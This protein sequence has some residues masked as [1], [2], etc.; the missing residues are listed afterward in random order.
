MSGAICTFSQRVAGSL[1]LVG[2]LFCCPNARGQGEPPFKI[3]LAGMAEFDPGLPG[4]FHLR[5]PRWT[6]G[7]AAGCHLALQAYK[8]RG[9]KGIV[10]ANDVP[11]QMGGGKVHASLKLPPMPFNSAAVARAVLYV[12]TWFA[13]SRVEALLYAANSNR[14]QTGYSSAGQSIWLDRVRLA[15]ASEEDLCF[16]SCAPGSPLIVCEMGRWGQTGGDLAGFTL[17][18]PTPRK[19]TKTPDLAES[20]PARCPFRDADVV[21]YL[22]ARPG[23][24]TGVLNA[25]VV[26][27]T[28]NHQ[29]SAARCFVDGG[30]ES[31]KTLGL[32]RGFAWAPR[33]FHIAG[34]GTYGLLAYYRAQPKP[35]DP[36]DVRHD[37]WV[38]PVSQAGRILVGH[39][40]KV[41]EGVAVENAELDPTPPAWHP[42]GEH[43]FFLQ[44]QPGSNPLY[45]AHVPAGAHFAEGK[46][47]ISS[48]QLGGSLPMDEQLVNLAVSCSGDGRYLA[49]IASGMLDQ[50][51]EAK[52]YARAFILPIEARQ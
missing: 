47:A 44:F 51:E 35:D 45:V 32:V 21:A 42:D 52:Y 18:D 27:R 25:M 11:A 46:V 33:T 7:E 23:M 50:D 20:R 5:Q 2:L 40:L 8:K 24:Q 37:L 31:R 39:A 1:F 12:G 13:D 38:V 43:L 6:P 30:T 48:W 41:F 19:L 36:A 34:R 17:D 26:S 15:S 49:L 9:I 29:M 14:D 16:P 4:D 22:E 28:A 10:I 3:D